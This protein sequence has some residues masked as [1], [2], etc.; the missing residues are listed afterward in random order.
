MI[1]DGAIA[2]RER[3]VRGERERGRWRRFAWFDFDGDDAVD[4]LQS[5]HF[6]NTTK[7]PLVP[8]HQLQRAPI[9]APETTIS[10]VHA[11]I[12]QTHI[13]TR[14]DGPTLAAAACASS[15]LQ[16]LSSED[17]LWQKICTATWPSINEPRV[18]HLISTFPAA[19]APSFPIFPVLDHRHPS[20]QSSENILL[21]HNTHN[22]AYILRR[23]LLQRR[24]H[25][26]KNPRNGNGNGWFHCSPFRVDLLDPKESVS[27]PI[28]HGG[29]EDDTWLKDLEENLSM[30]WIVID[31]ERKRAVNLSSRRAVTV[32]RQWLTGDVQARFLLIMGGDERSGM[33]LVKWEVVVTCGGERSCSFRYLI[34]RRRPRNHL[35]IF[36][37]ANSLFSSF[38]KSPVRARNPL[39]IAGAAGGKY[40]CFERNWLRRDLNVIG[41]GIGTELAHFPTPPPV[42]SQFW[43]WL[44]T[45]HFGL[46]VCLTFGQIGFKG[47]AEDYF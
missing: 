41:F 38:V 7:C 14:L 43:L 29:E 34:R 30:S 22:R 5:S 25:F 46:F 31:P 13:L 28:L 16:V 20:K 9:T 40:T 37:K 32:E 6:I 8:L 36:T 18:S 17:E 33:E 35:P 4:D 15:Q 12:I 26:I 19:T 42:T 2:K 27:T 11:D 1:H 39:R 23:Y 45:W 21:F 47:R 44:I 24:S 10:A 3:E